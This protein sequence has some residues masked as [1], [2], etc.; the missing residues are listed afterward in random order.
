MLGC[1]LFIPNG[2]PPC[3]IACPTDRTKSPPY[4]CRVRM[5][6]Q[7]YAHANAFD[8][9]AAA[10]DSHDRRSSAG[11]KV[12]AVVSIKNTARFSSVR[13]RQRVDRR[14]NLEQIKRIKRLQELVST[15]LPDSNL[16]I[17]LNYLSQIRFSPSLE[18]A[19][20]TGSKHTPYLSL[21]QITSKSSFIILT[22]SDDLRWLLSPPVATIQPNIEPLLNMTRKTDTHTILK[23]SCP[24]AHPHPSPRPS[25]RGP[26]STSSASIQPLPSS[27]ASASPNAA[28]AASKAPSPNATK[29]SPASY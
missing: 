16:A 4:T 18:F 28:P 13:A 22:T 8:V 15:P 26:Q 6:F 11:P 14:G 20:D 9:C 29:N 3:C 12:V 21:T 2:L 19:Q 23:V 25:L 7:A 27:H 5:P 10:Y 17:V 24:P 1:A